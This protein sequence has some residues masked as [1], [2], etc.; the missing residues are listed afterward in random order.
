MQYLTQIYKENMRTNKVIN[1]DIFTNQANENYKKHVKTQSK[2][3]LVILNKIIDWKK[4]V[5][6]IEKALQKERSSAP[7]G[8]SPFSMLVIVKCFILQSIYGLSDPRLEEEIADRRSFQIFL[9]INSGDS[10]P[11]D[12][13][14]CRYREQFSRLGLDKLLFDSFNEQLR[15]RNMILDRVTLVDATI[16][17]A[18]ANPNSNRDKDAQFTQKRGKTYY[19]YKGHIGVDLGTEVIHSVEFTSA[20]VHDSQMFDATLHGSEAS[21]Y[22]D[23][24]Y[25]NKRRKKSLES[26]GI[27]CGILEK[28]YRNQPL[29]KAQIARNKQLSKIRNIV[30]RPFSFMKHVLGYDRC[31]YYDLRRNRFQFII[32]ATV[33]NMRKCITLSM[34]AI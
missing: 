14:I 19:G 29:T 1:I 16:K 6:P 7:A 25:T 33:Y 12:T 8:R 4:L 30:E 32:N 17:Q 21:V 31:S 20:N 22:A 34:A 27:F 23:K 15:A 5:L 26:K 10:I 2:E 9:D 18:A 28:G 24:G 13:T 3:A 11:D